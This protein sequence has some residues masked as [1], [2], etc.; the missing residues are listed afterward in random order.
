MDPTLS[1]ALRSWDL[2]LEVIVVLAAAGILY[3]LGWWRLRRRTAANRPV[4]RATN[5]WQAGALWRPVL[6]ILGLLLLAIALMSPIDVLSAQMFT[7]HMVQHVFLVM[8]VP[9]LLLLANPLPFVLWGLPKDARLAGGRLFSRQSRVRRVLQQATGPGFVW[10]AFVIIYWG[11]H[12]PN[13]YQWA[14][15][16]ALAHDLE[17]ITFF[18]VAMLFWWHVVGAGPKIH[19]PLSAFA[20][21]GFAL[22]AIPPNMLAGIAF[23][24]AAEPIYAYYEAMPRLW[25]LTVMEDQRIAGLVMW[26]PG[27]MMFLVAALVIVARWL[28]AE[29]EK[30]PLPESEWASDEA[31]AAPGIAVDPGRK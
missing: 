10:L 27:S 22:S 21:A 17:H 25:G 1:A 5:R 2:R 26:V 14:L 3:S 24:F 11:W 4:A 28:Q 9:P 13:A 16:S 29:S 6:Y 23:V 30:P 19:R 8:I 18:L 7:M 12:D 15:R 20:R 31:L